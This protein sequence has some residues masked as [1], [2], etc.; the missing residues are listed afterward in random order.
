ML[1]KGQEELEGL[2]VFSC[3]VPFSCHMCHNFFIVFLVHKN[4]FIPLQN[5]MKVFIHLL[6]HKYYLYTYYVYNNVLG[7]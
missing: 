7:S 3:S 4:V 5:R 2:Q 6:H 1:K